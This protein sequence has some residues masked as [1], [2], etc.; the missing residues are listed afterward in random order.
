MPEIKKAKTKLKSYEC[1]K[2]FYLLNND[3]WQ[4]LLVNFKVSRI[5]AKEYATNNSPSVIR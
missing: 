2:H 1:P 3:Q 5:K 4:K